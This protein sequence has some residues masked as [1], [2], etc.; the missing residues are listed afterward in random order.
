M[1]TLIHNVLDRRHNWIGS[2]QI[3]PL[4]YESLSHHDI[5]RTVIYLDRGRG[6]GWGWAEAGTLSSFRD[7][8]IWARFTQG[9]TAA[10]CRPEDVVWAWQPLDGDPLR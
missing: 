4:T 2:W 5:G 10:A 1:K 9:D 3:V 7:G 8:M 6:T